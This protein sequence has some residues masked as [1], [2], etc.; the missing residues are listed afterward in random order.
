MGPHW[1]HNW[2]NRRLSWASTS[3]LAPS[4]QARSAGQIFQQ[5][6][7]Q[8]SR[9]TVGERFPSRPAGSSDPYMDRVR[10]VH[11]HGGSLALRDPPVP[12]SR[13]TRCRPDRRAVPGPPDAATQMVRHPSADVGAAERPRRG[14]PAS[15]R[16]ARGR[17]AGS[18]ASLSTCVAAAG[19]RRLISRS[20]PPLDVVEAAARAGTCALGMDHPAGY[21]LRVPSRDDLDG[22]AEVLVADQ[23]AEAGHELLGADF[24]REEWDRAGFDLATDAWVVIDEP[25]G[26]SPLGSRAMSPT[27]DP[28]SYRGKV[29]RMPGWSRRL[30]LAASVRERR[31]V[32]CL[33]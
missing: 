25:E 26:P 27:A 20:S 24:V 3:G 8:R 18:T 9:G 2:R 23:L 21:R 28:C 1:G 29:N 6:G 5:R 31:C 4:A 10:P 15:P 16:S 19:S 12:R 17:S 33:M 22:V 7:V 32:A 13:H 14:P 11:Q 30:G